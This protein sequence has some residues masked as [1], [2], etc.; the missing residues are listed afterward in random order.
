MIGVVALVVALTA[1][2]G[3]TRDYRSSYGKLKIETKALPDKVGELAV[4]VR[5]EGIEFD[6]L[7]IEPFEQSPQGVARLALTIRTDNY[8]RSWLR[9][10]EVAL[11]CD[12]SSDPSDWFRGS[13]WEAGALVPTGEARVGRLFVGFPR[14][15]DA[16]NYNVV[17][18]T[19]ARLVVTMAGDVAQ[20]VIYEVDPLMIRAAIRQPRGPSLPLQPSKS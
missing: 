12:E 7:D 20:R 18:C 3:C 4:P 5:H 10:P 13:T 14:K 16:P 15:H 8:S 9:N 11:R 17:S 19:N 6:L 2:T 1:G